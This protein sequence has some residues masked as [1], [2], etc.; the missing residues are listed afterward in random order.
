[1]EFNILKLPDQDLC[2]GKVVMFR[3]SQIRQD[4][5]GVT[6]CVTE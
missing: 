5:D 2:S 3:I 1:M 6:V 4:A